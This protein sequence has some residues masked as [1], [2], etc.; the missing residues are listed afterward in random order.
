MRRVIAGNRWPL[1]VLYFVPRIAERA[2]Y[3]RFPIRACSTRLDSGASN[4]EVGNKL[5]LLGNCIFAKDWSESSRYT[6]VAE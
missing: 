6:T 1:A 5:L 3:G 2:A 4:S